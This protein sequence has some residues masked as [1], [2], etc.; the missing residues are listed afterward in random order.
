MKLIWH[1][2]KHTPFLVI[3]MEGKINGETTR[4][5]YKSFFEEPFQ[6]MRFISYQQLE[7]TASD[8][9]RLV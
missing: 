8:K 1:L 3:I 6:R 2:L 5:P 9:R 4:R 7:E